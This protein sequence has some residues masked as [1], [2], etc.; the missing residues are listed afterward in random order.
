MQ[1]SQRLE[2]EIGGVFEAGQT[3]FAAASNAGSP[4]RKR[5]GMWR[6]PPYTKRMPPWRVWSRTSCRLRPRARTETALLSAKDGLTHLR[7]ALAAAADVARCRGEL[8]AAE[9][10]MEGNWRT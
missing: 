7:A 6:P 2:K 9:S 1:E 3:M 4:K 5:N 8:K 10:Y